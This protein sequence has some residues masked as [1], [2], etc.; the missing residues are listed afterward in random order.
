MRLFGNSQKKKNILDHVY[1]TFENKVNTEKMQR[2][3][4]KRI[5]K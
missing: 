5:Q 3:K 2:Q 1:K 4:N